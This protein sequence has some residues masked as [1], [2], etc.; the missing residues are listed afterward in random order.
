MTMPP[1]MVDERRLSYRITSLE[2]S[3][4]CRYT[5]PS[6]AP[7]AG[8]G[9]REP[10]CPGARGILGGCAQQKQA[11]PPM[12]KRPRDHIFYACGNREREV[13]THCKTIDR[14]ISASFVP[15]SQPNSRPDP[16]LM[17]GMHL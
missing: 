6:F 12:W 13:H 4:T 3:V 5:T 8:A 1:L 2:L 9:K 17:H 11:S 16:A 15:P 7:R 10:G 14:S